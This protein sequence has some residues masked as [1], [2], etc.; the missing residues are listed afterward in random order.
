MNK[1]VY[2]SLALC[3]L[4]SF[5]CSPPMVS[6]TRYYFVD[7]YGTNSIYEYVTEDID[8]ALLVAKSMVVKSQVISFYSYLEN[9]YNY[10]SSHIYGHKEIVYS[11]LEKSCYTIPR[12][13]FSLSLY[14]RDKK[15]FRLYGVPYNR[16]W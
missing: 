10:N 3:A 13:P 11:P 8:S 16:N 12:Y 4:S 14:L 6:Q 2:V 7:V 15:T 5:I 1:C 9:P